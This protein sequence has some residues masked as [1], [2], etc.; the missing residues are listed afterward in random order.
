MSFVLGIF[1]GTVIGFFICALVF[2]SGI[3]SHE[4]EAYRQG[5]EDGEYFATCTEKYV[6]L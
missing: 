5:Y 3:K 4:E 1:V 6:D 2:V